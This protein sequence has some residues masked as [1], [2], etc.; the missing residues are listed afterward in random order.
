MSF[1]VVVIFQLSPALRNR[2]T[3]IWCPPSNDRQDLISIIEH[4]LVDGIQLGNQEDG[5][6]GVGKAIIDF[7]EWFANNEAGKR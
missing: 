5:S 7:V 6:S 4:N 2:F 3:E 1:H